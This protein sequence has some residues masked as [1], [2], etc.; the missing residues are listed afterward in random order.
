MATWLMETIYCHVPPTSDGHYIHI[1]REIR[2]LLVTCYDCSETL[3]GS[4]TYTVKNTNP[5]RISSRTICLSTPSSVGITHGDKKAHGGPQ[6][7]TFSIE[8]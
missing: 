3:L 1:V 6:Q 4:L 5:T 7:Y 2:H 8:I